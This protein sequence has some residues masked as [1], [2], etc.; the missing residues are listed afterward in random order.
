MRIVITGATGFIGRRLVSVLA[1]RGDELVLLARDPARALAGAPKGARAARW[2]AAMPDEGFR[3]ALAGADAVVHLAGEPVNARR[4]SDEHKR[5]IMDTR[6]L[7]TRNLVRAIGALPSSERPKVLASASGVDYYGDTGD[8]EKSEDAGPGE[9][10]LA[11]VCVAWEREA[12]EARQHGAR[13]SCAR[14]GIVLGEGGGALEPMLLAFKLFVGGPVAGGRQWFPWLHVDDM[15]AMYLA[16]IEDE[17]VRAPFNAVTESVR[18]SEF[19]RALGRAM[20]RPSW[21]PVP[22]F[23]VELVMGEMG[24]VVAESKR[25]APAFLRSIDF[26]WRHPTL[27]DALR[28]ALR[29]R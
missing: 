13:V 24:R 3:D 26:R 21:M 27:D 16:A 1:E 19:S 28:D 20:N 8:V 15:V 6:V 9:T 17:R 14:T 18:M 2:D 11:K 22:R 29:R 5:N 10:F 4:W 7:G 12:L 25:I 23:A